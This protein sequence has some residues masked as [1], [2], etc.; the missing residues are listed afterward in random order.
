M[1]RLTPEQVAWVQATYREHTLVETTARFNA[2]YGHNYQPSSL[3]AGFPFYGIRSG[4]YAT[5]QQDHPRAWKPEHIAWLRAHRADLL[6][7][8]LTDAFNAHFGQTRTKD[9]VNATLDRF[10]ILSPRTG[11][12]RKGQTPWNKGGAPRQATLPQAFKSG[13][14][15]LHASPIG[16]R[17]KTHGIWRVK[18]SD[19]PGPGLSRFGWI[20]EHRQIW[21]AANGPQPTGTVIVFIDGD[22]EHLALDNLALLSRGELARLNQLGWRHLSD[23]AARRAM[24]AQ[25]RL[26]ATAHQLA[27]NRGLSP[28]VRRQLLPP[29]PKVR[30]QVEETAPCC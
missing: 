5:M 23:P 22:H 1:V 21:E 28:T 12:F 3:K 2:R 25:C 10:N 8:E 18:V 19:S 17:V 9:Q 30:P 26:L 7:T 11:N 6:I 13:G 24:I 20:E 4:R 15:L 16:T 29:T 27:R 14:P